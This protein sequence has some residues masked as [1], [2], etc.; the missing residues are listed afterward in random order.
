V[1]FNVTF[2][3]ADSARVSRFVVGRFF[4]PRELPQAVGRALFTRDFV[5]TAGLPL[6][7]CAVAYALPEDRRLPVFIVVLAW[8]AIAAVLL[9]SMGKSHAIGCAT[10]EG[11]LAGGLRLKVSKGKRRICLAGVVVEPDFRGKGI[12]TALLLAAFR[13]AAR[14]RERGPVT[15]TVFGPAHPASKHVVTKYFDGALALPVETAEG[16]TFSKSL[17][18]LEGEVRELAEKGTT[19]RFTISDRGLFDA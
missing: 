3:P 1:E 2:D 6:A 15:L 14:E 8:L 4:T 13:L 5:L 9:L 11:T 12:F 18:A 17:A 7:L 16:S 10:A 19:H